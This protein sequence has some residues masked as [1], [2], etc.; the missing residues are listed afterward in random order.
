MLSQYGLAFR[1]QIFV[2][3]GEYEVCILQS[4]VY[5]EVE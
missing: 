1:L 3:A 2:M 4:Q 5:K